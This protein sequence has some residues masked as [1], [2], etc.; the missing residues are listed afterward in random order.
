MLRHCSIQGDIF[1]HSPISFVSTVRVRFK[2]PHQ[3]LFRLALIFC[4][5]FVAAGL[6][7]GKSV[8]AA[9]GPVGFIFSYL[10]LRASGPSHAAV[11][12]P[13]H[14][15]LQ[16]SP[17]QITITYRAIDRA[18]KK[19]PRDEVWCFSTR[20]LKPVLY[21]PRQN[22]IVLDGTGI[23]QILFPNAPS[24]QTHHVSFVPLHIPDPSDCERVVQLLQTTVPVQT[25]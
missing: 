19:G 10:L 14:T 9:I 11:N 22:L 12:R 21:D 3:W 18:D 23:Q 16:L 4:L 2:Q 25:R 7:A 5:A 13:V 15:E 20:Q 17:E 1:M 6:L 8:L 24:P